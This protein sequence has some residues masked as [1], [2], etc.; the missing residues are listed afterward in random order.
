MANIHCKRRGFSNLIISK[1]TGVA[2][3]ILL[4]Y[5]RS[6][7]DK[8]SDFNGVCNVCN[9]PA[10]FFFNSWIVSKD[11]EQ[12]M[13]N[14]GNFRNLL[15]RES[16]FCSHCLTSS[17]KRALYS[18]M[19]IRFAEK[20]R[21]AGVRGSLDGS[22]ISILIVGNLG[23]GSYLQKLVSKKFSV[24]TTFF[25][26]SLPFGTQTSNGVNAD[27]QNLCFPDQTFDFVIHSDVLEHV[28]NPK[29][30][31]E[32]CL[33]VLK[34][35]GEIIFTIPIDQALVSSRCTSN[36]IEKIWHGRGKWIL[37]LLPKRDSY[38]ERHIF[39]SD[40][41]EY[42]SLTTGEPINSFLYQESSEEVLVL[43]L[44]KKF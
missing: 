21:L 43:Q 1:L 26:P 19:S 8:F 5:I 38:L 23:E 17:R 24:I 29:L 41:A 35:G 40:F 9:K 22:Q 2:V 20:S 12:R 30:A 31:L 6:P 34:P 32:N 25:N 11:I 42:L 3:R 39:G 13:S 10:K 27:I 36:S 18:H 14:Y 44:D 4:L 16:H 28:S 37:S 15:C 33:R 7:R